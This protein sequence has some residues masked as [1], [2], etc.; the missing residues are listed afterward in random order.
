LFR[1]SLGQPSPL[2]LNTASIRLEE[3][4][5]TLADQH[6]RIYHVS[7]VGQMQSLFG[8]PGSGIPPGQIAPPGDPSL[9]SPTEALRLD[10]ADCF[11]LSAEGY[12]GIVMNQFDGYFETRFDVIFRTGFH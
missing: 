7:H 6:P 10:G 1:G 5:A 9:P 8:F 4:I 11:H 2:Q 3:A 12:D